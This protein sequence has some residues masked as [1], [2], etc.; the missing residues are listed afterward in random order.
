MTWSIVQVQSTLK[1]QTE[2]LGHIEL[3]VV[4]NENHTR[5]QRDQ[6]YKCNI[7]WKW[8]WTIETYRMRCGH[9][10]KPVMT[11]A[12]SIIQVWSTPKT[13]LNYR[14]LSDLVQ[15]IMKTR[16]DN[17][18]TNHIGT[19]YNENKIGLSGP[20]KPCVVPDEN[21]TEQWHDRFYRCG[22]CQKRNWTIGTNRT[23]CNLWQKPDKTTTWAII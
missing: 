22:L 1:N 9:S 5:Q 11:T 4:S 2:L 23:W 18:M 20:I 6:S 19:V 3:S 10:W 21:Q 8:Y 13:I 14:D 15:S 12:W 16:L 17:N 7:F